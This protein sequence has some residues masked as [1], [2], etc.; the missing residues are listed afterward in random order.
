MAPAASAG[1]DLT[2]NEGD[3][4]VLNGTFTDPGTADTHTLTWS[5]ADQ[6]GNV[7]FFE[8]V[9]NRDKRLVQLLYNAHAK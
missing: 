3:T 2:A 4:V 5:V 9:Y 7:S 1:P 6:N 8:D